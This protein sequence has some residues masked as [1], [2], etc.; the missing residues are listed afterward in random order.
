MSN[1]DRPLILITNDDGFTAKG[2]HALVD[3]AADL[4]ELFIIAP[5]RPQSGMGH[6]ITIHDPLR[7]KRTDSFGDH[8]AYHCD[9]TPVDCVKTGIYGLMDR[10]PDLVLSG[11]N[12][13]ANY[14]INVLYSGTMSAA[15]EGAL[16][17]VPSI[18]FSL[19][20]YDQNADFT[21]S[22]EVVRKVVRE[23][24]KEGIPDSCCLNVNIPKGPPSDLNGIKICRQGKGHW[25]DE[26]EERN[27]PMGRP[28]FWLKGAFE[29]REDKEDTDIWALKNNFVSVVPVKFDM[30]AHEHLKMISDWEL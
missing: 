21:A 3:A 28:Y 15:V 25:Q 29:S 7:W 24:L 30:T 10:R 14:S 12:H 11:I 17:G 23:A 4:G 1:S 20:D 19:L 9:G 18:G 22:Q 8:T 5:E 27:D 13:G 26:F 6:A 16:E 2:I